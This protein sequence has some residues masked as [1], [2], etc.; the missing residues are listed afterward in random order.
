MKRDTRHFCLKLCSLETVGIEGNDYVK[1]LY[2]QLFAF[3]ICR[4]PQLC[5]P[6]PASN[7]MFTCKLTRICQ[8]HRRQNLCNWP[9]IFS[10]PYFL[11]LNCHT[12]E[13]FLYPRKL[14]TMPV[15]LFYIYNLQLES[16]LCMQL[17]QPG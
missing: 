8:R 9:E 12:N 11:T 10:N 2:L 7:P 6:D 1:V 13:K 3:L 4:V 17:R 14:L 5:G 16:L 15:L